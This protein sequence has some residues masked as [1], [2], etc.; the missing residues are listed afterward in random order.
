MLKYNVKLT[1]VFCEV[2]DYSLGSGGTIEVGKSSNLAIACRADRLVRI[3][4]MSLQCGAPSTNGA[5][6]AR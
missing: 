4:H 3:V 2:A 6:H 5:N 1:E